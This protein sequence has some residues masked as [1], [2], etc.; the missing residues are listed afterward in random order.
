MLRARYLLSVIRYL[1]AQYLS[2]KDS[3]TTDLNAGAFR[4]RLKV[5]RYRGPAPPQLSVICYRL[6]AE[7]GSCDD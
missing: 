3:L 2:D 4:D 1:A 6:S 5:I 7:A